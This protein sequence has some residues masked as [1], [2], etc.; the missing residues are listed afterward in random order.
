MHADN[1]VVSARHVPENGTYGV[2]YGSINPKTWNASAE[3]STAS[4]DEGTRDDDN[5]FDD[6]L[7]LC[8]VEKSAPA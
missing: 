1:L 2:I 5:D 8:T 6:L 3:M 4:W 7:K